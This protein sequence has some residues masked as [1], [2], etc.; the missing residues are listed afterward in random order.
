VKGLSGTSAAKAAAI[1]KKVGSKKRRAMESTASAIK[2]NCDLGEG[3]GA[4]SMG[5]DEDIMPLIDCANIACGYH[6]GDPSVM[7]RS[8]ALAKT[9]NVEIGAHVAY[10]D[11]QGFGRRSMAVRGQ[12]LVDMLHYQ[13]A[14]LDGMA[15]SQGSR[16]SYVKPHGALYNDMMKDRALLGDIMAAVAQWHQPLELMLMATPQDAQAVELGIEYG[17]SLRF[18]AFADRGY[19]DAGF[20]IARDKPNA[21]LPEDAAVSQALDIAKGTL[22][23]ARGKKLSLLPDTL[24][25]HGDTPAAVAIVRRIRTALAAV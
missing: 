7:R 10:P 22:S 16:V 18:E 21:L 9:H 13:I 8:I 19:T 20:L 11:L 23:S 17:L 1:V 3:Y 2:L 5:C 25:V 6:G 24:C 14:A 15:R 4:W 12:E